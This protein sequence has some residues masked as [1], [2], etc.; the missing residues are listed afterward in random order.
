MFQDT[1]SIEYVNATKY[2]VVHVRMQ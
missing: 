1:F 2:Y